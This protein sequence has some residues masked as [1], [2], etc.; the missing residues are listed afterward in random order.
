MTESEMVL[1]GSEISANEKI[2]GYA[3][4]KCGIKAK[5]TKSHNPQENSIHDMLQS[6]DL[7]SGNLEE[8]HQFDYFLPVE[9]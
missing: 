2:C 5:F 8:D 9:I 6:F 3:T 4:N 7:E 1:I